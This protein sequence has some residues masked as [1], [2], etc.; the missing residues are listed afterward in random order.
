[1]HVEWGSVMAFLLHVLYVLVSAELRKLLLP[2]N[3]VQVATV[4]LFC[5]FCHKLTSIYPFFSLP[6]LEPIKSIFQIRYCYACNVIIIDT[7][8]DITSLVNC[9]LSDGTIVQ[10]IVLAVILQTPYYLISLLCYLSHA[11]RICIESSKIIELFT[12]RLWLILHINLQCFDWLIII[13]HM[14]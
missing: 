3:F 7:D 12:L 2:R 10:I 11:V 1:M 14:V 9:C 8:W 6:W 13:T 4:S 5:R